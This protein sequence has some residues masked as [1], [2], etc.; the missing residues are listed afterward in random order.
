MIY[1]FKTFDEAQ[2]NIWNVEPDEEYYK[3]IRL[4]SAMAFTIN[5]PQCKRGLFLFKTIEEANEFRLK[6]QIEKAVKFL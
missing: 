2:K 4:L 1:K 6:D 5:P 3:Q